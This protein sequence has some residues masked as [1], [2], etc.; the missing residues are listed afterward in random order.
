MLATRTEA[1]QIYRELAAGDPDL[2]QAEYQRQLGALRRQYDQRGMSYEAIARDLPSQD[3][4][5]PEASS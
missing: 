5:H 3:T 1:V 2:Y 4:K